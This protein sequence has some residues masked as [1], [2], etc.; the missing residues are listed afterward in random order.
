MP[1]EGAAAFSNNSMVFDTASGAENNVVAIARYPAGN[2]LMS[3]FLKGG[4]Y[5]N[6]KVA[7]TEVHL[8]NGRLVLLGFPVQK[9]AQPHGTFKLLFNSLYYAT[10]TGSKAE[11]RAA[12]RH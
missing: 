6:G 5:L 12:E 4:N 2:L 7:A 9:R 10:S 8:G 1:K 3:G 11:N